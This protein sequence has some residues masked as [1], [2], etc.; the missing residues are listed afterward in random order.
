MSE[1]Y[2]I[3]EFDYQAQEE[4]E[5]SIIKGERLVLIDDNK[6]WW[7]ARNMNGDVGFVPS[8]FVRKENVNSNTHN[9]S[10]AFIDQKENGTNTAIVLFN[11][12]PQREDE[13][14][15]K[16]GTR[17][18]VLDK[19]SDGWWKGEEKFGNFRKGWFPSNYVR[20]EEMLEN[21]ELGQ[22]NEEKN[23]RN[24]QRQQKHQQTGR[25][26]QQQNEHLK[27]ISRKVLEIVICLYSF[28]A[29]SSQELSFSKNERLD[30]LEHPIDDPDWWLARNQCGQTGLVP[31][32]YI[33]IVER[34]PLR[35][36]FDN[37]HL[38]S[39]NKSSNISPSLFASSPQPCSGVYVGSNNNH[40][41]N[42]NFDQLS[43]P[44]S[45]Q[46]WYY[47]QI[48]REQ[49]DI[50]LRQRG[51]EGD[52]L[53]FFCYFLNLFSIE[54]VRDS[55]SMPGDFSISLNDSQKNKHFWIHYDSGSGQ[56]NIGNKRFNSMEALIIY[57]MSQP[58]F[59]DN[60][61]NLFLRKPLPK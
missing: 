31:T 51:S 30:I 7:K 4:Q 41:N 35:S 38:N 32:N 33:E 6:L 11:Y 48:T 16:K 40:L 17:L 45:R 43:G 44:Y 59:S 36:A 54:K 34:N 49:A 20:E 25:G 18:V 21:G 52:F 47:G 46:P 27:P 26:Q 24:V 22:E 5:L 37:I 39:S 9:A 15:L 57:Y 28:D 56:F 55:E 10:S 8:N 13:L 61:V 29:Q 1:E 2:I 19:S 23:Q 53:V 50:L 60:N 12:T 14:A 42:S 3:A 58:I